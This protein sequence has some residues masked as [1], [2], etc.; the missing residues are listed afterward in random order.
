MDRPGRSVGSDLISLARLLPGLSPFHTV[1]GSLLVV[2]S[3]ATALAFTLASGQSVG[4]LVDLVGNDLDSPA[5]RAFLASIVV[6]TVLYLFQQ[7][8]LQGT[9]VNGAAFARRVNRRLRERAMR[10]TLH[11]PTIDHLQRPEVR[12]AVDRARELAPA[13]FTPGQAARALLGQIREHLGSAVSAVT[14]ILIGQWQ[15]TIL[16]LAIRSVSQWHGLKMFWANISV[17]AG[18]GVDLRRSAYFRDLALRSEAAKEVRIFGLT[19]WLAARSRRASLDV[20]D[21]AWDQ[22][23][24]RRSTAIMAIGEAG[25]LTL[26]AAWLGFQAHDGRIT[27]ATLATALFLARSVGQ[28]NLSDEILA[29]TYGAAAVPA[30]LEL[31]GAVQDHEPRSSMPMPDRRPRHDISIEGLRYQYPGADRPVFDGLD[32]HIPAGQRLAIVGLN[33]AGKTTLVKLICGLLLP[34]GGRIA[35]DGTDIATVEP[36]SWRRSVAVLFQDFVRYE[37]SARTNVAFGAPDTPPTEADLDRLA[38]DV[39]LRSL[40]DALP[41]GWDTVLA[42]QFTGGTDL[43]G[44]Q[45]QRLAL[46]R[47]L[48]AVSGGARLLILDEPTANLD[49]RAEARLYDQFLDL[50]ESAAD[51]PLTTVLIS[52][53][54]STVRRADRILVIENGTVVEDGSHDE[55]RALDGRYA[56]LFDLQASRYGEAPAAPLP[57]GG[58]DV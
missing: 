13:G 11:P 58:G 53:R 15:L 5:G 52:H 4:R 2:A 54:F 55:L 43:S 24:N 45:W 22:R 23:R 16:A 26:A 17:V 40:V 30:I 47:A 46:A 29:V 34:D 37:L 56:R 20:L 31:E 35:V 49:V 3:S 44:G 41:D 14:L 57:A 25:N 51:D 9:T 21:V 7:V 48:H 8:L 50:T 42:P 10:A 38:D 32:L 18:A 36:A 39:G 27:A 28:F 12:G 6:V 19:D 33:G 1:I